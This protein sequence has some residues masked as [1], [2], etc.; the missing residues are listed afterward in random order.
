MATRS[1]N[2]QK[3]A[4][5][6]GLIGII[7]PYS[8]TFISTYI[9]HLHISNSPN[10][11]GQ[12]KPFFQSGLAQAIRYLSTGTDIVSSHVKEN[13]PELGLSE[14]GSRVLNPGKKSVRNQL[15]S[16]A[17]SC[18]LCPRLGNM[19]VALSLSKEFSC[20]NDLGSSSRMRAGK[21][22]QRQSRKLPT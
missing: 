21:K 16:L 15:R 2:R 6:G 5:S 8:L 13:S 9:Y 11:W 1:G 10:E 14:T 12:G 19:R 4:Q 22:Q 18:S 7:I 20:T 17:F 3:L